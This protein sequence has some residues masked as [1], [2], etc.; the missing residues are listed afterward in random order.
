[1]KRFWYNY[2]D[3][4]IFS[5]FSA[6]SSTSLSPSSPFSN[7]LNTAP[8]SFFS[9]FF[10]ANSSS[11]FRAAASAFL[12]EGPPARDVLLKSFWVLRSAPASRSFSV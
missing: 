3:K 8:S 9:F 11:I 2:S 10:S 4:F 12:W 6:A 7:A 5:I 1:M